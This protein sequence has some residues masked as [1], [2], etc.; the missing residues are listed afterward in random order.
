LGTEF[1][2]RRD[3]DHNYIMDPEEA[4]VPDVACY[5]MDLSG[6]SDE[7]WFGV[8]MYA[9]KGMAVGGYDLEVWTYSKSYQVTLAGSVVLTDK[10]DWSTV[11]AQPFWSLDVP[12]TAPTLCLRYPD[13]AL[14][15]E[16]QLFGLGWFEGDAFPDPGEEIPDTDEVR[17]AQGKI[18]TQ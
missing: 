8:A 18:F 11:D 14:H 9:H 4:L 7:Q 16:D 10:L 2:L 13:P 6:D 1:L 12:N 17:L 3:E 15:I 5:Q